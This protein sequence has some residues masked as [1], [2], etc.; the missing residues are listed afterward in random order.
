MAEF[1]FNFWERVDELKGDK[2]LKDIANDLGVSYA[3]IK[4]MRTRC[5]YPKQELCTKL[6]SYLSTTV[7]YLMTGTPSRDAPHSEDWEYVAELMEEDEE[8]TRLLA[9]I[10]RRVKGMKV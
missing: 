2:S 3:T 4:D 10:I 9:D 5:R 7:E 6:A 8:F 1:A